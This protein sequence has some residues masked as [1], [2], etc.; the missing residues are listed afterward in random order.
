[1]VALLQ[2]CCFYC[3]LNYNTLYVLASTYKYNVIFNVLFVFCLNGISPSASFKSLILF[4]PTL[5]SYW[6]TL[7][8]K[9]REDSSGSEGKSISNSQDK[10]QLL[11]IFTREVLGTLVLGT[12]D[13]YTYVCTICICLHVCTYTVTS[14][15]R[16]YR[17]EVNIFPCPPI[18][19]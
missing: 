15:R 14:G 7:V 19:E 18:N 9:G 11:I 10:S 6:M 5:F 17:S 4:L 12:W 2:I 1:M 13:Y 3:L 16:V 8:N